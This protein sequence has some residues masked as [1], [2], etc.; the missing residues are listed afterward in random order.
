MSFRFLLSVD[1]FSNIQPA[2]TIFNLVRPFSRTTN[3]ATT[4][5][6]TNCLLNLAYSSVADPHHFD[7]YLDPVVHC[8]AY[9]DP[10]T[11]VNADPEPASQNDADPCF[12][13]F[14]SQEREEHRS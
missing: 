2:A 14:L 4:Y 12:T 10:A 6:R 1:H 3:C 11:H 5:P 7:A 8:D 13:G 9:L